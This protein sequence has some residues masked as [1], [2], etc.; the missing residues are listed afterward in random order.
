M[1]D[2]VDLGFALSL[3]PEKAIAYFEQ[4]GYAIGFRWQ[5]VR[6][7]AHA[8]AFTVAGVMKLDVLTDVHDALADS[9]QRGGTL[10]DFKNRLRPILEAKGWWGKGQVVDPAT[11]EI[12]GRRL[13]P[14]RLDTIFR[15]NLQ[16]A[17]SAG[18][19]RTMMENTDDRPWWQYVAVMDSRTRPAHRALHGRIFRYDDPFWA[20][21]YPPNGY[22]CRCRV[23]ARRQ[24]DLDREQLAPD[25]SAGKLETIDQVIDRSGD[26]RPAVSFVDA[27]GNRVTPDPGF[28]FNPARAAYQPELDRYPA[29]VARQYVHG[30]LTGPAFGRWY[31]SINE[32]VEGHLA[33]DMTS[34]AIREA[35][36]QG[37]RFPVAV[38]AADDMARLGSQSRA[39]WLSD[40]TLAKQFAH[41]QGQ[42]VALEDYWRV[43][44]VLEQPELVLAERDRHLKFVRRNNRWWVAIVK[45]TQDG[46]ENWLQSFHP[47]NERELARLR[48]S[49]NVIWE[50]GE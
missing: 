27:A 18:R 10:A 3:P 21:H 37:Q 47:T 1:P 50:R 44:T 41:R 29:D 46:R 33:R 14:R 36:A 2:P 25:S 22:R 28:G 45:V 7:E 24:S 8:K 39:V 9:L 42:G 12:S 4:K 43:Q 31:Q 40:D 13:N 5:D 32:A 11:G 17:Y 35:V 20:T 48:K 49:G 23:R 30:T 38:L 19:Y 34:T 16:S 6:D 26:S 15:T